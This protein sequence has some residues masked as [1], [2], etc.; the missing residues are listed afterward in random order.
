LEKT[1]QTAMFKAVGVRNLVDR[2]E[3]SSSASRLRISNALH[4]KD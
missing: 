2:V 3:N 4:E 1:E